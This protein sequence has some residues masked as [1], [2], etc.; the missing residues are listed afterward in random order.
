LSEK[1]KERVSC[2]RQEGN[3]EK[4]KNDSYTRS[5]SHKVYVVHCQLV[6]LRWQLGT[7]PMAVSDI[8]PNLLATLRAYH[9]ERAQVSSPYH[10]LSVEL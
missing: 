7:A 4:V 3:E 6:R 2:S 9:R 5:L 1:K 8:V 10:L